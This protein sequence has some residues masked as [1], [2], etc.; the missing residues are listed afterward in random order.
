[1]PDGLRTVSDFTPIGAGVQ[2]LSD[3]WA[4]AAPSASNLLV[5]AGFAVVAGLLAV[6]FFRWE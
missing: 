1:M 6:K 4:G 3:T 2:A 5:M